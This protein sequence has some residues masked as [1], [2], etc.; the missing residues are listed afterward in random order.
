[1]GRNYQTLPFR[2]NP[3]RRQAALLVAEDDL[4]DH[5]IAARVGVAKNTI[6]TWKRHPTF[7]AQV[8]DHIGQLQASALKFSIAKKHKRVGDLDKLYRKALEVIELRAAQYE[9][10]AD[11]AEQAARRIFGN[12][13]VPE[14]ATGLLVK[15][16]SVTGSGMVIT[17]W[18]VDT[19]LLKEIRAFQEQAAKELG[20]WVERSESEQT[21]TV[22]QIVG[23]EA[24]AI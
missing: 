8:G 18:A 16:E 3:K 4:P 21:T 12:H 2:W 24:E 19:G 23:V 20:Q 7:M 5:E 17:E 6:E 9:G 13:V 22:V 15:K 11:T 1:M 14:A 10:T